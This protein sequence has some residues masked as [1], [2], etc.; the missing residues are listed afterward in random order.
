MRRIAFKPA[1]AEDLILVDDGNYLLLGAAACS[2]I[3]QLDG[4]DFGKVLSTRGDKTFINELNEVRQEL[5][6]E[7]VWAKHV[8]PLPK[9]NLSLVLSDTNL[10]KR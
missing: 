10:T 1:G 9:L 3:S 5:D 2:P 4:I 7:S 6:R 8:S